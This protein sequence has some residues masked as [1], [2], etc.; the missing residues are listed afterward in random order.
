MGWEYFSITC[1]LLLTLKFEN[2]LNI[3]KIKWNSKG[4]FNGRNFLKVGS[5]LEKCMFFKL[6]TYCMEKIATNVF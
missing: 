6:Q 2:I 5:Q 1:Y 4:K 3:Q